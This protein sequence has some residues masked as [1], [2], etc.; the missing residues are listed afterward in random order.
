MKPCSI[1]LA[2]SFAVA[3]AADDN[4]AE[5]LKR[6][7]AKV[8]AREAPLPNYTCVETVTRDYY[9]SVSAAAPEA[10]TALATPSKNTSVG[11]PALPPLL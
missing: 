3:A 8:L 10:C 4:P 7:T 6:V 9:Q 11:P 1:I 5:V 2:W